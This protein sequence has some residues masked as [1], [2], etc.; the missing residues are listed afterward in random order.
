MS[1]PQHRHPAH[2][3]QFT[4]AHRRQVIEAL[5]IVLRVKRSRALAERV[6]RAAPQTPQTRAAALAARVRA[7]RPVTGPGDI[8]SL[9][10]R[11]QTFAR[12]TR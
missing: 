9:I 6:R 10:S 2:R 3:R 4:E 12:R 1:R 7:A 8:A 11:T 5:R